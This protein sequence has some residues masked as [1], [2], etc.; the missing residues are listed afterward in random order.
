M[1]RNLVGCI[2]G[3]S[4]IKIAQFVLIWEQTWPPQSI[5]VSD[6][7]ISKNKSSPLRGERCS[8]L[9]REGRGVQHYEERG[10]VFNIMKRGARCSTLW[11]EGRGVQHYAERGEVFNIM[12]RG[13]RC[14]AL[15]WTPRPSLHNVEHLAPLFIMLNT[16]PLSS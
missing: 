3:R 15:C 16:S 1:N 9:W 7:S 5:L 12:Q 8:T 11:R 2:Y 13:A 10:E 14:S 6:W 4:A